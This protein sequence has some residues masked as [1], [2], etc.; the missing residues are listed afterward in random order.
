[1]II[2]NKPPRTLG[3]DEPIRHGSHK[4]PIS[5][6]DFISAGFLSGPALLAA[7]T[8]FSL[9]AN[10]RAARAALSPDLDA[11]RVTPCNILPGAGKIPFIAFDF[12]GGASMVGSEILIGGR[13]GQLDFLSTAGYARQ[14]LPGDMVPNAPNAASAT[15][16]FIDTTFG[17]AWHSDGA[18]LRGMREKALQAA[19]NTN[20]AVIAARSENDTQNNPHN[21]MYGIYRAGADGDLLTL[22]GSRASDSGGNSLAPAALM[23]PA[24]RPTKVDR[25]SD[26]TGLVDTGQLVG[27]LSERDSVAVLEAIARISHRK[28]DRIL[29]VGP[30]QVLRE[31]VKCGYVKAAD[32]VDRFGDPAALNPDLDPDIVGATGIFTQA[33]YAG[34]GEFRKTAAVMKMVIEGYAGAGTITMGGYDYHGQ[35]R[36]TGEVRNLRAGRCMGA[37]L[38]YARRK[39]VPL[40]IYAF[41]DGSLSANGQVDNTVDGRGKFMWASDNQSTAASFILLYDPN[42]RPPALRQQIGWFNADGSVNTASSPA[43]NNVNLLVMTVIL[44]YMA[45]HGE[46]G[47]FSALFPNHGLGNAQLQE[48]LI[49]FPPIVNGTI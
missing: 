3:L 20:A 35:G 28:A 25:A 41:S 46:A 39:G 26:V 11:M 8:I 29:N 13:G 33:E 6:R 38:E 18:F 23:D 5:R 9:F 34:D 21:P 16:D 31:L 45:L 7:P 42:G 47:A 19:P 2:R 44:N 1:M 17:A 49:A 48:S 22:I 14:G 4:R 36:S 43:A 32:L 27:L 30:D 40:M 12:A 24:V 10:P 15:N 37:C